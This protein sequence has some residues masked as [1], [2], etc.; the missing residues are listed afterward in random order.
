MPRQWGSTPS[1]SRYSCNVAAFFD[2]EEPAAPAFRPPPFHASQK[3]HVVPC[4][5]PSG[6]AIQ[7]PLY[8]FVADVKVRGGADPAG[9]LRHSNALHRQPSDFFLR[10]DAL[11]PERDNPRGRI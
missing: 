6:K 10:V 11:L 7:E 4:H 5:A 8:F 3:Y 9:P 1:R 2:A